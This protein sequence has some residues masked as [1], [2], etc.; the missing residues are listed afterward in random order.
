MTGGNIYNVQAII[1]DL[2]DSQQEDRQTQEV[3][4]RKL[5]RRKSK[6]ETAAIWS[7]I[8]N[9]ALR[10]TNSVE[11]L[12]EMVEKGTSAGPAAEV[13][14]VTRVRHNSEGNYDDVRLGEQKTVTEDAVYEN[15]TFFQGSAQFGKKTKTVEPP[16]SPLETR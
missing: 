15:V 1:S 6:R 10:R 11:D 3:V 5:M 8:R 13:R 16:I 9:G 12:S 7:E 4:I 14:P 2:E